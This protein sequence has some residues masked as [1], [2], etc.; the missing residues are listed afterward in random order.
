M[1]VR[2]SSGEHGNA[3][4]EVQKSVAVRVFDDGSSGVVG[5]ERVG[6]GVGRGDNLLIPLDDGLGFGA[7]EWGDKVRQI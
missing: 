1:G 3:C 6:A 7:R 5:D 4:G 2:V